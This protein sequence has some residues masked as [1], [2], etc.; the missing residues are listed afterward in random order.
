MREEEFTLCGILK[1]LIVKLID[2]NIRNS[3]VMLLFLILYIWTA[4]SCQNEHKLTYNGISREYYEKASTSS[5]AIASGD[6]RDE[7]KQ[8]LAKDYDS[9]AA[10]EY[11]KGY[12]KS[13]GDFIWINRYGVTPQAAYL[14]NFL[15][16]IEQHGFP[17]SKTRFNILKE[18]FEKVTQLADSEDNATSLN[19]TLAQLEY[20]LTKALL[21]YGVGM[22]SG[23]TS[24]RDIFNDIDISDSD[25]VHV[26][27]RQL[28]D[29][30]VLSNKRKAFF[31][32][33]ESVRNDSLCHFLSDAQPKNPLYHVLK[34]KLQDAQ[35]SERNRIL[36][37]MERARWRTKDAPYMHDEYVIVNI[38]SYHLWATNADTTLSMRIGCGS[39]KTKTPLLYSKI[40]HMEVNPQWIIPTSIRKKEL[41]HH[42]GDSSYFERNNYYA[43]NHK[44][45]E[46]LTG[47]NITY[48]VITSREYSIIQ[49]GGAGNSLGR[50]IF[51]FPNNHSVYLHDTS[52]PSVFAR[53]SRSVSHGCVRVEKPFELAKFLLR[54]KHNDA[55]EKIK[56]SMENDVNDKNI[57]KRK[58]ISSKNV[59]PNMPL[60]IEYYTLFQPPHGSVT[61]YPDVYGYDPLLLKALQKY[62]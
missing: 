35:G 36:V 48:D 17:R 18:G 3:I 22:H 44:T 49:K 56:Y 43:L 58:I 23:F 62:F 61:T 32:A 51:R 11:T 25:S 46:K 42:S 5:L 29:I 13:G 37:N 4:T 50:I 60:Y 41:I 27:Y 39:V 38:P 12:Y 57:D 1:C 20:Y 45:K 40:S 10:D 24:P 26:K 19:K 6:V 31:Q 7:I 2:S 16:T 53:T 52:S 8:L 34:K 55:V 28:F 14:I 21:R 15:D 30:P 33:I 59:E 9:A 54:G 47:S